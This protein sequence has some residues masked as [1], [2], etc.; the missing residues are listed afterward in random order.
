MRTKLEAELRSL[1][2]GGVG[3]DSKRILLEVVRTGALPSHPPRPE[4]A[5]AAAR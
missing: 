3:P 2:E 5:K 1:A 4:Q